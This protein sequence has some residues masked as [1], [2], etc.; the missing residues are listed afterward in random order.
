MKFTSDW[1]NDYVRK[2]SAKNKLPNPKPQ[3]PVCHE[4]LATDQGKEGSSVRAVVCIES[5]RARLL[6]LDNLYGGAKF[7]IDAARY[8]LLIKGDATKDIDLRIFQTKVPKDQE[9]TILTITNQ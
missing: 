3:L 5:R 7:L 1:L 4:P 6:D 8:S 2:H 9:V